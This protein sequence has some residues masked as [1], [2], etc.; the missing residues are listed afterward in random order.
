MNKA[1]CS[2]GERVSQATINRRY[3]EALKKKHA[4]NPR[5]LCEGCE[6]LYADHNDHTIAQARCK[7]LHKA[8]LIWNPDNFPSS[9]HT[10][11]KEWEA[12]KSGEW[13]NHKNVEQRLRFLRQHDPEGFKTRIELTELHLKQQ[14]HDNDRRNRLQH[15]KEA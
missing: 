13:L 8:E 9:C 5:P 12:F 7:V 2:N 10:C 3:S 15:E 1:F 4:G 11:H 6:V 14:Q